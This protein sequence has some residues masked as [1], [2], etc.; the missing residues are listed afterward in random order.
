[1]ARN[2]VIEPGG[3][4]QTSRLSGVRTLRGIELGHLGLGSI[5]QHGS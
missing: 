3:F 4:P 2:Q 1:M 5:G